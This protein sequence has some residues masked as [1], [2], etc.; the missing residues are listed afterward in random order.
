M[1]SKLLLLAL[2]TILLFGCKTTTKEVVS[3]TQNS[4]QWR[5][6]TPTPPMGWNSWDSYR[7]TISEAQFRPIVDFFAEK[8]K[9]FGWEYMVVDMAWYYPGPADWDMVEPRY[10]DIELVK[11]TDGKVWGPDMII[12]EYGRF[13][14]DERRFPSSAG[15]KGFKP[16]ADYVH[17]KGLKFG[18]HIMRGIPRQAVD[19]LNC[20]IMGTDYHA[21][22]IA[23]KWDTVKWS[24]LMYGVDINKPGAQEYY[25]AL[26][27]MYADWGVDFI[28][29]DDMMVPPYHKGEIEMMRKAIDQCGRPM[30]LSLSCGE[31][32][33]SQA[34]HL[35]SLANMWRVSI[36][37]WDEWEDIERM[38]E[39]MKWW[40]PFIGKNNTW[41]DADMLPMGMLDVAGRADRKRPPRYTNF[42]REEQYTMM[43]LWSIVRSPLMWGGDPLQPDTF[44]I[45][46]LTNKEILEVNQ[47]S[48]NNRQIYHS[49]NGNETDRIWMADVP[50]ST[51]KYVGLFNLSNEAQEVVFDFRYDYLPETLN[52]RDLWE[53]KDLGTFT[54]KFSVKLA[55]HG[56]RLY[57][58]SK[59]E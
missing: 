18:I 33:A 44:T 58:I 36:D 42:T 55:P 5:S 52:V 6:L 57:R 38:F 21:A 10:F 24:N 2:T 30:V 11:G 26:F 7:G 48:S 20:K 49:F 28:K 56:G 43:S 51:D 4:E 32:P 46:L 59:T 40:S 41:P 17:S 31:A 8:M 50:G 29:A 19:D 14:P 53:Q 34:N 23:V 37:V 22:D 12:D 16:L 39:L 47:N 25:N 54:G 13:Q 45:K 9:P 27:K 15:G 1:K 3:S 35:A